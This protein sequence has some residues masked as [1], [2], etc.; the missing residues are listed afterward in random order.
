MNTCVCATYICMCTY[1]CH[2]QKLYNIEI[3]TFICVYV[4]T[5]AL[6]RLDYSSLH[7]EAVPHRVPG[8]TLC[9]VKSCLEFEFLLPPC[10]ATLCTVKSCLGF[11]FLL[12]A[13]LLFVWIYQFFNLACPGHTP[14][15]P[16]T[17]LQQPSWGGCPTQ[18]TWRNVMHS[19][20]MFRV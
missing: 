7:G 4:Y 6:R 15:P 16:Q 1:I 12:P 8:A 19:Q 2:A 14:L 17:Y 9:T 13:L 5:Q 3:L 18:S 10:G 20:I 11:E